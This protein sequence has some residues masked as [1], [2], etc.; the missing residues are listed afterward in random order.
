[1]QRGYAVGTM[2]VRLATLRKY[3]I[4]AG[5]TG[6]GVIDGEALALILTVKGAAGRKARNRDREREAGGIATRIGAKKA[7]A[8]NLTAEQALALKKAT[9]PNARGTY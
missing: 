8:T 7:E 6:A 5:P 1:M 2:N 9:T 4:L 3:C